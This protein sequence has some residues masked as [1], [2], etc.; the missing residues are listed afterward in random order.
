MSQPSQPWPSAGRIAGID[1]GTVRIGVSVCDSERTLASPL[2]NYQRRNE[3]KDAQFFRELVKDY[4]LVGFVVGLPL[5]NSGDESQKS[6]ESRRFGEWLSNVC[7]L[8]VCYHDERFS[9]AL[10][11][12][13]LAMGNLTAKQRKKRRDK[14]AAQIILAS[15]LDAA[16]ATTGGALDD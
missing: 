7:D 6:L 9:S 11:E 10:A 12:Q 8:P 1:Y 14:L 4:Q 3:T 16:D 15:F 2:E 13:Y 5:H